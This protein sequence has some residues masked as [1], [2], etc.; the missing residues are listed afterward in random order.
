MLPAREGQPTLETAVLRPDKIAPGKLLK[1]TYRWNAV[2]VDRDYSVFV[3]F[4]GAN[5]ATV[6]Q[7][8]HQPPSPTTK[9]TGPVSETQRIAVPADAPDGPYKIVVGLYAALPNSGG[10]KNLPLSAGKGVVAGPYSSYEVGTVTVDHTA[11]PP[12][13]DSAKPAT[14][15]L[16]GYRMTFHDEFNDLSVSAR[17]PAGPKGSRWIAHKP[18]FQ[19]FGDAK[20]TEPADGFP[21]TVKDGILRIEAR[22]ESDGWK[23]GILSSCDPQGNGFAQKYGYFEMRAKFPKGAGNWP[24]FWMLRQAHLTDPK[25]FDVE[26]D[27]VEQYGLAPDLLHTTYHVWKPNDHTALFDTNQVPDMSEDFHRYGLMWDEKFVVCYFDG[28]ELFRQPTPPEANSPMYLLVDLALGGGWPIDKTPNPSFMLV[29]YVR[30]Y[31]KK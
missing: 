13:L 2:P 12:P 31:A 18:D 1:V 23:A 7:D 22:K 26:F 24:A 14:L 20:F 29:D 10:W 19:D 4:V 27:I 3:H 5:G 25:S 11:P 8:D 15:D 30:A 28:V 17:G 21:F 6:F 16:K 9:W